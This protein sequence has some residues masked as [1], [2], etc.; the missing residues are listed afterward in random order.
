LVAPFEQVN[1]FL[2]GLDGPS[3]LWTS[4]DL[5]IMCPKNRTGFSN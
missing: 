1:R 4:N 3:H 5:I 2:T